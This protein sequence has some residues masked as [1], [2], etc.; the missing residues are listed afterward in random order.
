MCAVIQGLLGSEGDDALGGIPRPQQKKAA[1]PSSTGPTVPS[2]V[3]VHGI[4]EFK[5]KLIASYV[6]EYRL[7]DSVCYF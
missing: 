1:T 5:C 6:T 3:E 4:T 2:L 7:S